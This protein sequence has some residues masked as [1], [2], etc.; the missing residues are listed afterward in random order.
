MECGEGADEGPRRRQRG[1][2]ENKTV[3]EDVPER[4]DESDSGLREDEVD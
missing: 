4:V 1:E 2:T 3:E